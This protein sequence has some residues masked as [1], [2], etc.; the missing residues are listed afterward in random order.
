[1]G[2][3]AVFSATGAALGIPA[4]IVATAYDNRTPA[5]AG[6][7][8]LVAPG[9]I[10]FNLFGGFPAFGVLTLTYTPEPGTLTLLGAGVAAL[11]ML[12]R[13]KLEERG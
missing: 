5:G 10:S 9:S 2:G 13:R 1:M 7:V 8:Q 4:T 12:G 3:T 6:T 11:A